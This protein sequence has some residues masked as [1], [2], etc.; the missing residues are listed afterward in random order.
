MMSVY[1][2]NLHLSCLVTELVISLMAELVRLN[3]DLFCSVLALFH[4]LSS[5]TH[6]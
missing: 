1:H 3:T 2:V 4:I 5:L 6:A